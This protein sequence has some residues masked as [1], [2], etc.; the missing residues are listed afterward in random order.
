MF[1]NNFSMCISKSLSHIITHW[2]AVPSKLSLTQ[3]HSSTSHAQP[4]ALCPSTPVTGL[5]PSL[6]NTNAV[7]ALGPDRFCSTLFASHTACVGVE[8][9]QTCSRTFPAPRYALRMRAFRSASSKK[10]KKKKSKIWWHLSLSQWPSSILLLVRS[11]LRTQN[12][13]LEKAME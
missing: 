11:H 1:R 12:G 4:V 6:T 9:F 13:S 2:R 3:C 7:T 8:A 5:I 10:K